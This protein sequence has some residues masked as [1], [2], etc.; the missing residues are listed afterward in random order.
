VISE[1]TVPLKASFHQTSTSI[2]RGCTQRD[3]PDVSLRYISVLDAVQLFPTL[4]SNY[5]S[6]FIAD[7]RNQKNTC[8]HRYTHRYFALSRISLREIKNRIST[9]L[10]PLGQRRAEFLYE[11][12]RVRLK[13]V[14]LFVGLPPSNVEQYNEFR[15]QRVCCSKDSA[16]AE[17]ASDGE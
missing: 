7:L 5:F 4:F 15:F 11:K 14:P 16:K 12:T 8:A 2:P 6:N 3:Q 17:H 1:E 9:R 13:T 10:C